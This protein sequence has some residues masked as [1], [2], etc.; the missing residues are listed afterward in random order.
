MVTNLYPLP[1]ESEQNT[2]ERLA[3]TVY[4]QLRQDILFGVYEPGSKLKSSDLRRRY[5]ASA[6]TIREAL[7][8]LVSERLVVTE[9][10]RGASVV[11][12]TPEDL[13]DITETRILLEC[14]A[15]RLSLQVAD[16]QWE[17]EVMAAHYKLAK[18]EELVFQDHAKHR[19]LLEKYDG[20]FHRTIISGCQSQWVLRFHT[21]MYDHMLR[22]RSLTLST[23]DQAQREEMLKRAQAEHVVLRD[24]A[25]NKD[26]DKL[27]ELLQVHIR[28]G[29]EFAEKYAN[30]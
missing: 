30:G 6:N 28:N 16:L 24:A 11:T 14:Q 23:I 27:V 4:L 25:L 7:A 9:G 19:N 29:K 15:V 13:H 10:Q 18:A 12:V 21:V 2:G 8:R 1:E 22:Y 5:E 17:G 26:A 20:D 3:E